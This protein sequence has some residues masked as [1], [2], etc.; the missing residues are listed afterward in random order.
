[1]V[2]C[3]DPSRLLEA[4]AEGFLVNRRAE[5]DDPFPTPG[6]LLALRQGALRDDLIR[7]AAGKGVAG[8]FDPPLC[9]FHELPSWL[10]AT[11]REPLGDF[12]RASLLANVV[13]RAGG[14]ILGRVR[15]LDYFLDAIEHLFGE[16]AS[17][18]ITPEQYR[19]AI[20][21]AR[22]GD[23]FARQRNEELAAVYGLYCAELEGGGFRDSRAAYYD[24]SIAIR[25]D[26][27]EVER[28]LGGRR[29]V[30]IF[31]LADLRGGWRA[32]LQAL[33]ESP[34]LDRVIVYTS[35][36]IDFPTEIDPEW[37]ALP[38]NDIIAARLFGAGE[39]NEGKF[40]VIEA[41]T[42][43]RE[44]GEVARRV[45]H[46][47]DSGE[48]P[49]RIAVVARE[50]R[51]YLDL[52]VRALRRFGV[53]VTAR[54]RFSYREIPVVKAVM[55]LFAAAADGWS[56]RSVIELAGQPYLS[57]DLDGRVLS[58]VSSRQV[59]AGL[60]RWREALVELER[61]AHAYEQ[62]KES[63]WRNRPPPPAR[64]VAAV[65]R[66]FDKFSS[67]AEQLNQIRTL[68]EWISWLVQF[69]ETDR[70]YIEKR[71]YDVPHQRFDV[72]KR[73]LTAWGGL[74]QII[75]EWS[76]AV[77]RW[78]GGD[79]RIDVAEFLRRLQEVLAADLAIWTETLVGVQVMEA[80]AVAY[81]GF[82]HLFLVGM[83]AGKFPLPA[84]ARPVIDDA[85]RVHLRAYGI[86]VDLEMDWDRRERNLFQILVGGAERIAL[87]YSRINSMGQET[88][89]SSFADALADVARESL[90][91]IPPS[92]VLTPDMPL[93]IDTASLRHATRAAFIERLR[94]TGEPSPY[95]GIIEDSE[96]LGW[97]EGA[98]GDNREWS[99]TQLEAYAKCPW[100]YFS[101]RV[102]CLEKY[103]DPTEEMEATVQGSIYHYAL[104]RFF[105][106]A[107][108]RVGGP[109]FLRQDDFEWAESLLIDALD[110]TLDEFTHT[111]W[112][113]V[114][115]LR[116]AKRE[117]LARVLRGYLEW[118][119]QFHEDMYDSRKK[120][121]PRILRTA[122]LEHEVKFND[123]V[124]ER[125][126]IAVKYRG[127]I[128]RVE[129]GIDERV[130]SPE[131]YVAAIDYKSSKASVPGGGD[132]EAW[133]EG[134]V[135]Q[136]P[137]YAHALEQLLPGRR[138]SSIE[139]RAL[140]QRERVHSLEL[141]Q[142]DKKTQVRYASKEHGTRLDAALDAVSDHVGRIRAGEFPARPA[143][144]C[145][146]PPY[147]HGWEICRT[148]G[149]P[150]TKRTWWD[151]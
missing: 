54:R 101:S 148:A 114:P 60:D 129:I 76:N 64:R 44:L 20:A 130:E 46:L 81:R 47:I 108:D 127:S 39:R 1:V 36:P 15:R 27:G 61:E 3:T 117:E 96:L 45:R 97:L 118:E 94:V 89:R 142:I 2:T 86:H 126:G 134:V 69:V 143:P 116:S 37:I 42:V 105:E 146:C 21:V 92:E 11:R 68:A 83:E 33:E 88:I 131:S 19:G 138:V 66:A 93:C 75:K 71:I 80:L 62:D 24:C 43:E 123:L 90:T 137:L 7:L 77:E 120:I 141:Q 145:K 23:E 29:E 149:G 49:E 104:K 124:V 95:N 112:I 67:Y 12:E 132:K 13:R 79:E 103:E 107:Q 65:R 41:P 57:T 18:G 110:K 121:A 109:V 28:L 9:V 78:G 91:S 128:D 53:P 56:R 51:P 139:Y 133:D 125:R 25:D 50:A 48:A 30:R 74:Q 34:A 113:G 70:W 6:Y 111:T 122:V 8:W 87:S 102:L 38:D 58:F 52:V 147:C 63:H 84:P 32:L 5:G 150:Q 119:I 14:K 82:D 106:A 17:E 135:L 115:T 85:D 10:G 98:F 73:D 59:L 99:P 40:A 140:M 26:P 100:A 35:Q 144:S 22:E 72:A 55:S 31:G 4:A 151:R 16:L 136:V